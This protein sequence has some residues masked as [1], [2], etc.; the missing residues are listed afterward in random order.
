MG[1]EML[2][3]SPNRMTVVLRCQ[4]PFKH[5]AILVLELKVNTGGESVNLGPT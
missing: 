4:P 1:S 2:Q 5:K 3:A